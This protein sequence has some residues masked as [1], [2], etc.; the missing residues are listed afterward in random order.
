VARNASSL[1]CE[2]TA[3]EETI[4]QNAARMQC[5]Y[6]EQVRLNDVEYVVGVVLESAQRVL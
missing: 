2:T 6:L 5:R 4:M 1:Q 3:S